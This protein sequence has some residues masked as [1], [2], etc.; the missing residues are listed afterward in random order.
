MK[1]QVSFFC[2]VCDVVTAEGSGGG[3][4]WLM[5]LCERVSEVFGHCYF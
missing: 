3:K 1:M 2:Q 5:C 4:G